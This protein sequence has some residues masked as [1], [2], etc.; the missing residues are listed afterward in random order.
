MLPVLIL[1]LLWIGAIVTEYTGK[2]LCRKPFAYLIFPLGFLILGMFRI[3]L[4]IHS[5]SKVLAYAGSADPG[6]MA[7]DGMVLSRALFW[8]VSLAAASLLSAVIVMLCRGDKR[9]AE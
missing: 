5:H 2:P 6:Q 7:A 8:I 1:A 9:K 4:S 3:A